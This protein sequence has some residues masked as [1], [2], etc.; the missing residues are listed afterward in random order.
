MKELLQLL[1]LSVFLIS[2]GV[3][4]ES[5]SS[6]SS[7]ELDECKQEMFS[8]MEKETA[9]LDMFSLLGISKDEFISCSCD[10]L[11]KKFES[12]EVASVEIEN[13]SEEDWPQLWSK[14]WNEGAT[15]RSVAWA[16]W[17]TATTPCGPTCWRRNEDYEP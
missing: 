11:S 2:C 6:W 13:L 17:R 10:Q 8:E 14:P 7:D 9:S 15:G 12:F 16:R 5:S 1:L 4:S 3:S